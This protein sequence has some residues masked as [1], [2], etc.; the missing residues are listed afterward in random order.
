MGQRIGTEGYGWIPRHYISENIGY[1]VGDASNAYG[2]VISPLWIER[3]KVAG[4]EYTPENG[5]D[6]V[7]LK[8]YRRHIVE[9]GKTGLTFIYDELEAEQ[10]VTW[11]YL[12]H[13]VTNPMNVDKSN[14]DWV[15]VQA[16]NKEG[17]SDAYLF[18]CL[19]YTSNKSIN[20]NLT[21]DEEREQERMNPV[22][23]TSSSCI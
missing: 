17:I 1:V 21:E 19:L 9:L 14:P 18:S 13:T 5:W 2:K 20:N 22:I 7:G 3:G 15:H 11:S 16:T 10:P 4:L 8:T 6:E 12:L 23:E